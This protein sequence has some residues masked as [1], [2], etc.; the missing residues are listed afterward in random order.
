MPTVYNSLMQPLGLLSFL[1]LTAMLGYMMYRWPGGV[2][3]TFSQNAARF[4]ESSI[5]Y[6]VGLV[7]VLALLSV[8]VLGWFVAAMKLST[9]FASVF[10]LGIAGQ[11]TAALVPETTGM[12]KTIHIAASAVMYLVTLIIVGMLAL[13]TAVPVTGRIAAA[14][15][16]G[17]ML[18]LSLAII[19]DKRLL[20]YAMVIQAIHLAS[21]YIILLVSTYSLQP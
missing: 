1:L 16:F 8:F 21:F 12:R 20:R 19:V 3:K 6:A 2:D 14:A 13:H 5:Y 7:V 10:L 4:K 17:V 15:G 9:V 18:M 11:T